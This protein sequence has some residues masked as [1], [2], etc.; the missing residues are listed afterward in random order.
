[1]FLAH[2]GNDFLS[3]HHS[4]TAYSALLDAGVPAELHL[5]PD[6]GHG[7]G[8]RPTADPITR[9]PARATGWLARQGLL[10]RVP[11]FIGP[12]ARQLS[13]AA[14]NNS[15]LPQLTSEYPGASLA[16]AYLIQK[17]FIRNLTA[18]GETI[19]GFKGAVA[20]AGGQKKLGIPHALSAVL[21]SSGTLQSSANPTIN[22][23]QN[24]GTAIETE[25]GFVI[26]KPVSAKISAIRELKK[27]I[28]SIVPIIE[29][30]G[31]K[32]LDTT[33]LTAADLVARNI[34]SNHQ[35]VGPPTSPDEVDPDS[36][37]IQLKHSNTT[38]NQANGA[39]ADGGQWKNLLLQVNHAV[40]QGYSIEPGQLVITGALGTIY[41]AQPGT[42]TASFGDL[43]TITFTLEP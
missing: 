17:Q 13:A 9:W 41:N 4:I 36:L 16:D 24:P 23:S 14:T 18:A 30:P 28:R 37:S 11:S 35:I 1:M 5:Y 26:D 6:G 3:P 31:G 27:H 8:L 19:A 15:A 7:F 21:L 29:L 42:Y 32:T 40:S 43:G 38:V 39:D 25:I 22:L 2:A 33:P 12:F 10:R 20:A 34:G